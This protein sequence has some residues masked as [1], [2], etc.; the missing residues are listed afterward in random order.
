MK[1]LGLKE[2]EKTTRIP[3][4]IY[5]MFLDPMPELLS[6][7][8]RL[9]LAYKED[10]VCVFDSGKSGKSFRKVFRKN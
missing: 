8:S 1:S 7:S 9:L 6:K 2:N 4:M 10:E 5:P 3:M